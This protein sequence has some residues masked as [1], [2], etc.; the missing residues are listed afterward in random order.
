MVFQKILQDIIEG[1]DGG[2]AGMV[3][4]KD[5][6]ALETYVRADIDGGVDIQALG[7]PFAYLRYSKERSL[8]A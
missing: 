8:I 1:V 5:G 4:A 3:I 6:I 7:E 2:L